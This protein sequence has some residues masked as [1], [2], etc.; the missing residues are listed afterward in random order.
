M[1]QENKQSTRADQTRQ[2]ILEAA[3]RQFSEHGLTGTRTEKIA[4][5]ASVNKALL[6]YYFQSKDALYGAALDWVGE[7]VR[8][9]SMALLDGP[10]SAGERF[11]RSVLLHFDRFYT[12]PG[13]KGLMQHEMIR[14]HAEE[15]AIMSPLIDKVLRPIND[16]LQEV[17]QEAIRTG[18]FLA[19]D[20]EQIHYAALG[21]NVFYFLSTPMRHLLQKQKGKEL[22]DLAL[23]RRAMIE[24]QGMV[25]FAERQHGI[26]VAARVLADTPMP[27][28]RVDLHQFHLKPKWRNAGR[29]PV[30]KKKNSRAAHN[31]PTT[32]N[33]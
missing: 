20:P 24:Y 23:R 3:A 27:P 7:G 5:E 25:L 17:I 31:N 9:N 33:D 8:A 10:A 4:A 16:R 32:K 30:R 6:Y 13:F 19:V 12:D 22:E 2:R 21:A 11:V 18:E 15:G 1:R 28:A 26:D 29:T 14:I